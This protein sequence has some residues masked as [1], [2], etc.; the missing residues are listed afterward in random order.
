MSGRIVILAG[1]PCAGKTTY[2]HEHAISADE[3]LD[4]DVVFA[5]ISGLDLYEREFGQADAVGAEFQRRLERIRQGF[6][7]RCAPEK[8]HRA[9]LRRTCGATSIV[10]AVPAEVCH[11]RLRESDRPDTAKQRLHQAIDGWWD[12]YEPSSSSQE[13][14][15]NDVSRATQSRGVAR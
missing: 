8:Q 10:L 12:L 6:V 14:V 11:A 2:A 15:L 13:G 7:I 9:I 1:P 3:I 5:E 4:Y